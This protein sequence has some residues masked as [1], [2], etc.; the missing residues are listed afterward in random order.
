M[1][2][3][4]SLWLGRLNVLKLSNILKLSSRLNVMPIKIPTGFFKE[5]N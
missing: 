4:F 2:N 5:L 3:I 1:E